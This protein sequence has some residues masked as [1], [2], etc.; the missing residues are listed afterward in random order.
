MKVNETEFIP[1]PSLRLEVEWH[2]H[3]STLL[4]I[5]MTIEP[6][7]MVHTCNPIYLGSID[8]RTVV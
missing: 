6:G 7:M 8:R 4:L 3:E 1:D 5:R 2:G